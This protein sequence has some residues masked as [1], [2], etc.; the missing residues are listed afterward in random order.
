[1][2]KLAFALV[3]AVTAVAGAETST[4]VWDGTSTSYGDGQL[5]LEEGTVLLGITTSNRY[6]RT[7]C[8]LGTKGVSLNGGTLAIQ[9]GVTN[10]VTG[11]PETSM[12]WA[13]ARRGLS[14]S[15]IMKIPKRP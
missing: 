5:V 1:M 2:K 4:Y 10:D 15:R 14:S 6:Y 3:A 9:A 8:Q 11:D 13:S 12:I 7:N